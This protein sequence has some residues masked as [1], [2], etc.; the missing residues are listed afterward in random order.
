MSPTD[1]FIAETTLRVRYKETDM[2]GFVHHSNYVTYFEEARSEYAR[3]RG[4]PYS[5]FEQA[6]YYLTVTEV[7]IRYVK[8]A[9]YEQELKILAWI[10]TLK[11]RG[12][13]FAYEIFEESSNMLLV[14]G[15]TNHICITHDGKVAK[16]PEMWRQWTDITDK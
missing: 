13:T 2:M 14:T 4:T 7:N 6:G 16:L 3:Q 9:F 10:T 1:R 11:S 8:P 5:E 15:E 12:L